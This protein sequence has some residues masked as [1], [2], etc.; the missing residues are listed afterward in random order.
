VQLYQKP[1]C[2]LRLFSSGRPRVVSSGG[3]NGKSRA[4]T[5]LFVALAY[6]GKSAPGKRERD[7]SI[8][9]VAQSQGRLTQVIARDL[10]YCLVALNARLANG[11]VK[12][13]QTDY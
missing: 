6:I 13:M 8:P 9:W 4:G 3:C 11:H 1:L 7:G 10:S 12:R 5:L 2:Q